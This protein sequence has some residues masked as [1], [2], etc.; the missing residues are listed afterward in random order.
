MKKFFTLC[1]ALLVFSTATFAQALP[2]GGGC[3][4]T[5]ISTQNGFEYIELY[6]PNGSDVTL[7]EYEFWTQGNSTPFATILN[8][9]VTIPAGGRYVVPVADGVLAGG[10]EFFLIRLATTGQHNRYGLHPGGTG[11]PI[12]Y[13]NPVTWSG[14]PQVPHPDSL[15]IEVINAG[16]PNVV[17]LPGNSLQ[18]VPEVDG[19]WQECPRTPGLLNCP[20]LPIEIAEW[21]AWPSNNWVRARL[22]TAS[23]LNNRMIYFQ[24][25]EGQEFIT[26]DSL[27]G[28]GSSPTGHTYEFTDYR[29]KVGWNYYRVRQV[30][31]DGNENF[32]KLAAVLM[33][34]V[35]KMEVFPNPATNDLFLGFPE[36]TTGFVVYAKAT[37]Q[38][39]HEYSLDPGQVFYRLDVSGLVSGTY[40]IIRL[41]GAKKTPQGETISFIKQ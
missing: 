15:V 33:G 30:D 37:G 25:G 39:A 21:G 4:I 10:C 36:N 7:P 38:L 35:H 17:T 40:M 22:V 31:Y 26:L 29:P 14:F 12:N 8:N 32:S 34:S 2:G 1:F 27:P 28:H 18:L 19:E 9:T 20:P 11:C 24:R 16:A 5:E 13:N 6:N 23:E 3:Y 41:E